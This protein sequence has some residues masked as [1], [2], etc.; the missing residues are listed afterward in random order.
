MTLTR[1][2]NFDESI[3]RMIERLKSEHVMFECKLLQVENNLKCNDIKQA[4]EIIQGISDKIIQHA[5]E[6][7]ARLMRVIMYKAKDESSEPIK[8]MQEHNWVLNFLKNTII[9]VKNAATSSDSAEKEKAK[10]DL[11]E[12]VDNLRKHFKEEEQIVFPLTLRSQ[13]A[14]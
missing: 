14:G 3:P 9:T 12:F 2:I 1:R 5:V 6:E 10:G 8:I 11:N 7:E 13:S 4:A